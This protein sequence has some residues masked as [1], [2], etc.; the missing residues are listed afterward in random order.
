[1]RNQNYQGSQRQDYRSERN[2]R[3][4][5]QNY[6]SNEP[7]NWGSARSDYGE[8][9]YGGNLDERAMEDQGSWWD[10]AGEENSSRFGGEENE[11]R[12]QRE[13]RDFQ[14]RDLQYYLHHPS[15]YPVGMNPY[16]YAPERSQN[17]QRQNRSERRQNWHKMQARD[18]MTRDVATVFPGDS[19]QYAARLMRDEDCGAIPVVNR[20]GQLIGMITDRD[21][22]VRLV[23][24]GSNAAQASVEE[25]MTQEA[26]ACH[27]SETVRVCMSV[28]SRH[29]IRRLPIV[30]DQD[31]VV[32]IV[33]QADLARCAD[34]SR[35]GRGKRAF[36][37]LVEDIS[38]P[39]SEAY[40]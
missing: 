27:F 26:F 19:I 36:T 21:I 30:D 13:E 7:R 3:R 5:S 34:S 23:A 10:Q 11:S 4:D 31:R 12:R 16:G 14:N 9:A 20:R 25:G 17:R 6:E 33:S 22:T 24:E 32:G 28:M 1:M 15:A 29:Q 2:S 18:V 37:D 39:T 40:A 8:Y 38:E 35:A